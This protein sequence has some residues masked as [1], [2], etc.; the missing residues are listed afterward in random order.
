MEMT[1]KRRIER[2]QVQLLRNQPF[3]GVPATSLKWVEKEQMPTAA[4]DGKYVYFGTKFVES[5][6]EDELL[7]V[8][9]HEV[10]HVIRKHQLRR[11]DRIPQLWNM[12][13][14][15]SINLDLDKCNCGT[16]PKGDNQGL[17]DKRFENMLEERIYDVLKSEMTP[18]QL[19]AL[20]NG[21]MDP[22]GC[23]GVLDSE[24]VGKGEAAIA[25]E[26][27]IINRMI[28][29]AAQTAK[30]AGKLP[31]FLEDFANKN[32]EPQIDWKGQL[33]RFIQP[34]FPT[35][36]SWS[37]PNKRMVYQGMYTPGVK[38]DGV[39]K[40]AVGLDTSG[41]I[42]EKELQVFAAELAAIFAEAKPDS[43][44]VYYFNSHV[45]Q[46]DVFPRG[47]AME[48]PKKIESGGTNFQAVFDAITNDNVNPRCLIMLTDMYDT[49]PANPHYPVLW[50]ATTEVE[51][52]YGHH[53]RVKF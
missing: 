10:H 13:C 20:Q 42:G 23:G 4:T 36:V 29:R 14:D 7:F 37:K 12:A 1:V 5:L 48:F 32:L 39:G 41:S 46:T 25:Q 40:M 16:M 28:E 27:N 15:Y 50:C 44:H 2:S 19:E 11:G 34:L 22:G 49:F 21:D 51:A 38:K 31:G 53:V 43:L 3:F 6:S 8:A 33:R 30:Q 47:T 52:P 17:L 26:N 9:A 35:D 24:A 18:E 45:W